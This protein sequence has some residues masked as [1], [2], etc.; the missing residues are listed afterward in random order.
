MASQPKPKV[1]PPV[2]VEGGQTE[3]AK[4]Q[5][6]PQPPG[7]MIGEGGRDTGEGE[8]KGGMIGEG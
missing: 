3:P 5:P 1:Q 6:A 7:G 4:P 8:R 2:Q